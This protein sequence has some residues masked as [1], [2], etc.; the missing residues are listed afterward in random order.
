MSVY[1]DRLELFLNE[2][3]LIRG[4][5]NG[6]DDDGRET[7]CLL[8]ALVPGCSSTSNCPADLMPAWLAH[9][10]PWIDDA[11]SEE[12]WMETVFRFADLAASWHVLSPEQWR[13]LDFVVRGIIVQ[14]AM[15]HTT[16]EP[17]LAVCRTVLALCN[18]T[19]AGETITPAEWSAAESAARSAARS[20][21]WSA[22]SAASAAWSAAADRIIAGILDAIQTA[23]VQ[24]WPKGK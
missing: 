7:A 16:D 3:R 1:S 15:A 18:R 24:G 22:E 9:L 23:I 5:W 4:S 10:T 14:E 11:G 21:A 12:N 2:G 17:V 19:A 20:A 13:R 8:A 6:R